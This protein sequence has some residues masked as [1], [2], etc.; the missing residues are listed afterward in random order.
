MR[1]K[2]KMRDMGCKNNPKWHLIVQGQK[3]NL[4]GRYIEHIGYWLPKSKKTYKR[5]IV[6]NKHKTR[7]WLAMGAEPTERAARILSM[8]DMFPKPL[9]PWGK[10]SLYEKPKKQYFVNHFRNNYKDLRDPL[11]QFTRKLH[12]EI[13][14]MERRRLI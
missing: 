3:K 6:I 2:I 12:S 8:Y 11:N 9:T 4:K 10:A 1:V 7:Y 5:G 14:S 13:T